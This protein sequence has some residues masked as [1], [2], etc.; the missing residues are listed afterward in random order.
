M[1]KLH[2]VFSVNTG[3]VFKRLEV[4]PGVSGCEYKLV[5]LKS[6]NENGYLEVEFF[7]DLTSK[8]EISEKH[9]AQ[10]GDVIVRLS[11]PY[12]AAFVDNESEGAVISSLFA[13]LRPK[14][15]QVSSE[16]VS[17]FLNSDYMRKQYYRDAS[18]SALQM[19]KTSSLKSYEIMIPTMN[20]Q[21]AIIEMNELSKKEL[22]LL[23]ELLEMK[24]MYNRLILNKLMEE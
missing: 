23:E 7:E 18:G 5:T 12:T 15:N 24:K 13:I 10:L 2:E 6:M 20:K 4:A 19:I 3:V 21:K 1:H 14:S 11:S 8:K 16:Y 9:I 17:I 22:N